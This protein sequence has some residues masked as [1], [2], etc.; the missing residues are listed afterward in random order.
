[1]PED[2]IEHEIGIAL[3]VS[4]MHLFAATFANLP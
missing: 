3:L 4:H 1:M 2:N